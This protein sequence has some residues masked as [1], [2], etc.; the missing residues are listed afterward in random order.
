[1]A[2]AVGP[3]LGGLLWSFSMSH[4]TVYLSF[5]AMIMCFAV[6]LAINVHM[7]LS[8]DHKKMPKATKVKRLSV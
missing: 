6:C 8:L 2:R 4:N 7:P 5:I 1:L 3:A